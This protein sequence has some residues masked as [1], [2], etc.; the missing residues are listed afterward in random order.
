MPT[1]SQAVT[2]KGR[3]IEAS[4]KMVALVVHLCNASFVPLD[5][6]GAEG[7]KVKGKQVCLKFKKNERFCSKKS[8]MIDTYH[9]L[10]RV[11]FE[12]FL[13]RTK[14]MDHTEMLESVGE[15]VL[16]KHNACI[17]EWR[18]PVCF[19]SFML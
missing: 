13:P 2:M 16:R 11:Y 4:L 15:L 6:K 5:I 18:T 14:L 1:Y 8:E 19:F 3:E 9:R 17:S 10:L 7:S 12:R